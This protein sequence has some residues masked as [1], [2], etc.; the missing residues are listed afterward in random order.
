[1]SDI[2]SRLYS[3]SIEPVFS[4]PKLRECFE[5]RPAFYS[6]DSCVLSQGIKLS[7]CVINH[8]PESIR[9]DKYE[10]SYTPLLSVS[11]WHGQGKTFPFLCQ[12]STCCWPRWPRGLRPLV[13]WDCGFESR[14]GHW[15]L[16]L[17]S[18]VCCQAEISATGRSLV[19]RSATH[20]GVSE[21]D[22]MQQ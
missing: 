15:C 10:W 2:I 14:Q 8:S 16:S 12:F 9:E 7:R 4:S 11:S 20:C 19:Q 17:F 6:V 13:F 3:F 1:M 5:L 22:Q 21:C 18:V